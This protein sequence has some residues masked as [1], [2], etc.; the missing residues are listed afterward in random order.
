MSRSLKSILPILLTVAVCVPLWAGD[1][2]PAS[3]GAPAAGNDSLTSST[4]RSEGDAT[5]RSGLVGLLVSKGL[6]TSSEASSLLSAPASD[7]TANLLKLLKDKGLISNADLAQ[8]T[9]T[10]MPVSAVTTSAIPTSAPAVV[11]AVIETPQSSASQATATPAA[12]P[13]VI[14]AVAP[15]RVLPIDVPKQSGLIPDI[16]LGSGANM[17]IYGFYKASAVSDTASSGGGTFGSN[18]FPLPLLLADTG[19]TSD[20]QVHLKARSFRVGM[21]TEWVPKDSDFSIT[22]RVEGDF[23]GDYTDV[24]NR[25][26]SSVRN[27]QFSLRLAWVRLDHKIGNLPWFAQFGQDWTIFGSSTLPNLFETTGL[28]IGMG[29]LYERAPM[30]RTGI[31]LP[32]GDFKV[33]PEFAIV[34]PVASTSTLTTDQ[35]L[36]FGD[37]AGAESNQPGLQAR[38]VFQFPLSH[39][40]K[41]VAPAQL[42]F[43]GERARINEIIPHAAQTP[44]SFICEATPCTIPTPLTNLNTPN[45]GFTNNLTILGASNCPEPTGKCFL[46]QIFPHGVQ[47]SN[48]QNGY[49]GEIQLPTPWV[50]L[51]AKFYR[52]EDLR[53]F[54]A[55]QLNDVYSNLGALAALPEQSGVSFSGKA[56]TFGCSGGTSVAGATTPT[57]NCAG[58]PVLPA[59]L[60]PVGGTGGFAELSFPLSRIFNANP[61]GHNSGWVL[62]LQY[63]TD[64]ANYLDAQHGNHLGRTDLDTAS[65]T[66]RLN[67]WVTFVHEA[68]YIVTFTANNHEA[69]GAIL[70]EKLPFA[71][72]TTR[73]AHNWRNEFGP[74]F[75]F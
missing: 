59:K 32:F 14:P 5:L 65:L 3:G 28:G 63:G 41:G 34:M 67:K 70:P 50:T 6:I 57:F 68:S 37:R 39:S 73:Q 60:Q 1:A 53:F 19:P 45:I 56:I 13:A 21:Q 9:K 52:G 51:V 74:I 17:K 66:Y 23:E 36:R 33:Q 27:G 29:S 38:V 46:G 58:N 42:I 10:A 4:I 49:T 16:K 47:A 62:H 44:T 12:A 72:S 2:A 26:I 54:F 71:G 30:F 18:D 43:S 22:G 11:S 75:T 64:R 24:N 8:V 61:E 20:P 48:L 69:S 15:L 40:W 31:Q 55:T 7:V 25:N 35:R